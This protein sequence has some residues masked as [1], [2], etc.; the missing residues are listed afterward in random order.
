[1]VENML[2]YILIIQKQEV[3]YTTEEGKTSKI[4]ASL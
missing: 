4:L 2:I 3:Y 1:M